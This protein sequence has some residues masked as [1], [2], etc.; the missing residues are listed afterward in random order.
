[1]KKFFTLCLCAS[2]AALAWGQSYKLKF[3]PSPDETNHAVLNYVGVWTPTNS[4]ATNSVGTNWYVFANAP[5]GSSNMIIP[6]VVPS[7]AYLAVETEGTNYLLTA[8]T[9]LVLYNAA[10]LALIYTNNPVP[11]R[12]A[13]TPT[14]SQ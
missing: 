12:P 8:P 3:T 7:P 4:F 2:V 14:L 1:M 11:P 6:A 10:A 5:V 9:N 13:G